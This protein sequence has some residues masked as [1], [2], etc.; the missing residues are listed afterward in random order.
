MEKREETFVKSKLVKRGYVNEKERVRIALQAGARLEA[1]RKGTYD[2][3][4]DG[5]IDD[6]TDPEFQ[7]PMHRH[8]GFDIEDASQNLALIEARARE[9]H[10]AREELRKTRERLGGKATQEAVSQGD[11]ISSEQ[12]PD[13]EDPETPRGGK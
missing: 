8:R 10:R 6:G 11:I 9:R 12:S 13:P 3:P 7:V 5:S 1:W 2:Y 4:E